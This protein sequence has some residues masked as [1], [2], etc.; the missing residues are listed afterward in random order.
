M[1]DIIPLIFNHVNDGKTYKSIL[2]SSKLFY[3]IMIY[4]HPHKRYKVFNQ[5]TTLLKIYPNEDWNWLML[6][7]NENIT[8]DYI[9]KNSDNPWEYSFI[10]INP[11]ITIDF[12]K[13]NNWWNMDSIS[14]NP[15][16]TLDVIKNNMH[17]RWNWEYVSKNINLTIDFINEHRDKP[18]DW[19]NILANKNLIITKD[20]IL[21]NINFKQ[22]HALY[23]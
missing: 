1:L 3:D 18:W 14:C 13:E 19:Y 20:F 9:K 22:L 15:T 11:N 16:I 21:N 10:M 2:Y 6:S 7:C 4:H 23:L 17:L 5:L 12:I 8:M